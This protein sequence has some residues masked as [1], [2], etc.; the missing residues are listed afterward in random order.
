MTQPMIRARSL[1]GP[2]GG[3]FGAEAG[4][5]VGVGGA[6]EPPAGGA[7]ISSVSVP[8]GVMVSAW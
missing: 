5:G 7:G 8:G 6:P 1:R 4:V 2:A 3:G